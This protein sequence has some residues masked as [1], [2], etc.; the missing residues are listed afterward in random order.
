MP[1]LEAYMSITD[2]RG[3]PIFVGARVFT[4]NNKVGYVVS[5]HPIT[6]K[7]RVQFEGNMVRKFLAKDLTRA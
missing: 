1:V 2:S 7:V 4:R 6:D 5:L 3:I